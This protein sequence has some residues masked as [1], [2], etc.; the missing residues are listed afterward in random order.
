MLI[1]SFLHLIDYRTQRVYA[2][3][4]KHTMLTLMCELSTRV[5][6]IPEE[7]YKSPDFLAVLESMRTKHESFVSSKALLIYCPCLAY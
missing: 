1:F 2:D 7:Y 4:Y 5:R 3:L 6:E